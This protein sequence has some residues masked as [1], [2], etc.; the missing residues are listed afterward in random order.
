[1]R[2]SLCLVPKANNAVKAMMATIADHLLCIDA[3]NSALCRLG[4]PVEGECENVTKS[5]KKHLD[6]VMKAMSEIQKVKAIHSEVIEK[7]ATLDQR[8]IGFVLHSE[9]IEVSGALQIHQRLGCY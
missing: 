4:D 1:M 8:T 9:K 2:K 3:W 5:R 7:Y 6:L